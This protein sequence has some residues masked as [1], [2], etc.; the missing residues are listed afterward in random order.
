MGPSALHTIPQ[1]GTGDFRSPPPLWAIETSVANGT[2]WHALSAAKGVGFG[3]RTR[4]E[5]SDGRATRATPVPLATLDSI[6]DRHFLSA[7]CRS[8]NDNLSAVRAAARLLDNPR[9]GLPAAEAPDPIRNEAN[10]G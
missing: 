5:R 10:A 6:G 3:R 2:G 1:P 7:S 9:A 4:P 8:R